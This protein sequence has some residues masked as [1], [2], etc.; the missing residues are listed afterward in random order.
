M[1]SSCI[2]V[3]NLPTAK[4]GSVIELSSALHGRDSQETTHMLDYCKDNNKEQLNQICNN[5]R[6]EI[7]FA[8]SN[9]IIKMLQNK[10]DIKLKKHH[11]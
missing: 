8:L 3:G 11:F 9:Q 1:Y 5:S 4:S 7:E 10:S 2:S 6:G